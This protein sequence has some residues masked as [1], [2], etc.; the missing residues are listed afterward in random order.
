MGYLM[1]AVC[2]VSGLAKITSKAVYGDVFAD[3]SNLI[4]AAQEEHILTSSLSWR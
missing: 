1:K 2:R 3:A 4:D